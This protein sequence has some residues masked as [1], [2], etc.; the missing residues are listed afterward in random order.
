MYKDS[1]ESGDYIVQQLMDLTV[2]SNTFPSLSYKTIP[3]DNL[4]DVVE[5]LFKSY[6]EEIVLI[7]GEEG[8]GK[9]SILSDFCKR[10]Y[11]NAISLFIKPSSKIG[12]DPQIVKAELYNQMFWVMYGKES[13]DIEEIDQ[14]HLN[15]LFYKFNKLIRN[16]E[17]L[18]FL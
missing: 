17:G 12:Y 7:E 4:L 1:L 15:I 11:N 8:A 3:L 6:N 5:E 13:K 16:K 9:T 18:Y 10:Y 2:I 14:S